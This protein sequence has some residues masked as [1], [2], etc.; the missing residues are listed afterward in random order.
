MSIN[1]IFQIS[2]IILLMFLFASTYMLGRSEWVYNKRVSLINT[3]MAK[4]DNL[5]SYEE[6]MDKPFTWDIEKMK[7]K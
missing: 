7:K 5:I 2:M 3:D 6:M 1:R 4:Y